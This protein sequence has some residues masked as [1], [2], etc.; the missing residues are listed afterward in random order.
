M[1]VSIKRNGAAETWER[2][3]LGPDGDFEVLLRRPTYGDLVAD[4]DRFTG[5]T[6]ARI[7][8]LVVGWRGV[9]RIAVDTTNPDAHVEVPEE[10]PFSTGELKRLLESY[11]AAFTQVAGLVNRR[12]RGLDGDA[13]KNSDGP[14]SPPSA[15]GPGSGPRRP[16]DTS[17]SG[18]PA[19][20][21][22]T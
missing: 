21:A 2:V 13:R 18:G 9:T 10:V 19:T 16:S 3:D 8:A 6:A 12:F 5:V 22:A 15:G 20:S 7:E 1:S 14:P 4:L 11:P 17:G